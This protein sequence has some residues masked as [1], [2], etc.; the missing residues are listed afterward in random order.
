[1]ALQTFEHIAQHLRTFAETKAHQMLH[2]GLGVQ[3]ANGHHGHA[4]LDLCASGAIDP[5]GDGVLDAPVYFTLAVGSPTLASLGANAS[6]IL[7]SRVG[8]SG[9]PTLW[10]SGSTLGLVSGDAFGAPGYVRLSFA[11]GMDVIEAGLDALQKFLSA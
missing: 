3:R 7:R 8:T 6:D 5:D 9:S 4:G 1:M 11:T 10:I 2:S